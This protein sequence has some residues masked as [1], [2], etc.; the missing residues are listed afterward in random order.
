MP[1]SRN[2]WGVDINRNSTVGT[3]F[4]G[5]DGASAACNNDTYAGPTKASEPE[6]KNE[7]SVVDT[8][9]NIKFAMNIHSYGGYFMWSPGA[10]KLPGR[11]TLPAPNIGIESY[12]F[13]GSDLVLGRIKEDRQTV[14]LPERTGPICDVLY[15]A[16][17]NSADDQWYRRGI[18]SYSFETGADRFT[19]T[20]SE[21]SQSAVGFQPNY[22]TEGQYEA[23]EFASGNYGLLETAL[24]YAFDTTP[25]VANIAPDGGVSQTPIR[26]TFEYVNEPAVIYYTLDGSEPTLAS[27]KWEA[28]GPRRPG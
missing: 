5:Y 28:Q 20:T 19:S 11:V 21:T 18:I 1:S 13:A 25:P 6:I 22:A 3:L 10:Y 27:T 14:I 7:L 15:S 9:P 24:Q 26:A 2:S 16:A 17:G 4:D 8:Y 23:L 12:F